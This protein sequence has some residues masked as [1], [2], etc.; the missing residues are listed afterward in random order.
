[1]KKRNDL[2]INMKK[3]KLEN[4]KKEL[5][6]SPLINKKSKMITRSISQ[7]DN[8]FNRLYKDSVTRENNRKSMN[9]SLDNIVLKQCTF[10]PKIISFDHDSKGNINNFLERNNYYDE[11]KKLKQKVKIDSY[12]MNQTYCFNPT[13]NRYT[14][15]LIKSDKERANETSKEKYERLSKKDYE[16]ICE[17]KNALKEKEL[18]RYTFHPKINESSKYLFDIPVRHRD[19]SKSRSK[20]RSYEIKEEYSFQPNINKKKMY[21]NHVKSNYKFDD[22]IQRN[23]EN[24]MRNVESKRDNIRK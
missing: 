17:K 4:D 10:S 13:I 20:S 22:S 18:A 14:D 5:T 16:Y 6:Y 15:I 24:E 7:D 8:T 1:M 12:N 2:I 9:S 11:I 23:I 21:Y 19:K 3:R